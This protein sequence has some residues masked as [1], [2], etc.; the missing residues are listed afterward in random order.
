MHKLGLARL[1]AGAMFLTVVGAVPAQSQNEIFVSEAGDD[2][3]ADCG[4][5]A[6]PCRSLSHAVS[7]VSARGIVHILPGAYDGV[8]LERPVELIADGGQASIIESGVLCGTSNVGICINATA[9]HYLFRIRGLTIGGKSDGIAGIRFLAGGALHVENV[10]LTE[11]DAVYAL[12]F[13][14]SGTSELYVS[15]STMTGGQG[16]GAGGILIRP[17]GSGSANVVLKNVS[18]ENNLIGLF[19][20]G[21][22]AS[23]QSI[24][25]NLV[26]SVIAGHTAQGV[27]AF[28]PANGAPV[29]VTIRNSTVTG[30]G[31]AGLFAQGA[32]LSGRGSAIL[33][34]GGSNISN[35]AAGVLAYTQGVVR[36]LGGNFVDANGS[37]NGPF[38]IISPE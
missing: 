4:T 15:D 24:K 37:G 28:S 14:P 23:V 32:T 12:Q 11:R 1:V 19:A 7:K 25:V 26:D 5:V 33:R 17:T 35:N 9:T 8:L 10:T 31:H 2:L 38:T 16:N 21:T 3:P 29:D 18:L 20:D 36:S 13:T 30:N 22:G 34:F 27:V 6:K